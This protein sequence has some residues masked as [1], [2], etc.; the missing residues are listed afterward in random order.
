[1]KQK[2]PMVAAARG[3][4]DAAAATRGAR[5]AS[6]GSPGSKGCRQRQRTEQGMPAEV[7]VRSGDG[8]RLGHFL[9]IF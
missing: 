5:V 3:T 4:E 1:V 7:Q 6:S 2:R 9:F 8:G